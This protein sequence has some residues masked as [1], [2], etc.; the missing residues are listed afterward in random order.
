MHNQRYMR[1]P[2]EMTRLKKIE[3]TG[4]RDP[5]P[6]FVRYHPYEVWDD[7]GNYHSRYSTL[8]CAAKTLCHIGGGEVREQY[9][10]GK[11]RIW[12]EYNCKTEVNKLRPRGVD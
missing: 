5:M 11:L 3:W 10:D 2:R 4:S 12:S 8:L 6:D 1:E 7:R 9:S